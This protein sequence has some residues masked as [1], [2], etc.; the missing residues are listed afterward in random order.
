MTGRAAAEA[1]TCHATGCTVAVPPHLLM[2]FRHWR[3]VP[4]PLQARVYATYRRGQEIDKRPS[5]A[6][7]DAAKAAIRAV[8]EKESTTPPREP[9]PSA[10]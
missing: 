4:R 8:A 2:C 1:H 6:Y 9:L 7:L 5:A 3:L 10:G